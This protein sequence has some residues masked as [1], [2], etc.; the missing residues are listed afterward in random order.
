M[1]NAKNSD[2]YLEAAFDQIAFHLGVKR[3]GI[4]PYIS[5]VDRA[6]IEGVTIKTIQHRR[7]LGKDKLPTIKRGRARATMTD[8]LAREISNQARQS[9]RGAA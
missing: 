6:S 5:D 3:D 4:P 2:I 8:A 9:I 7:W 1:S